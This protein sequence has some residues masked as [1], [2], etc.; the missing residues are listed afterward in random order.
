[1]AVLSCWNAVCDKCRHTNLIKMSNDNYLNIWNIPLFIK[2]KNKEFI[3]LMNKKKIYLE[4]KTIFDTDINSL[5]K[6]ENFI[7]INYN[8]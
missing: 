1:M 5:N 2:T 4:L 8:M 3:I 7:K 6:Y